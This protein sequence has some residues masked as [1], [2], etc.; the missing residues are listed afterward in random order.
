MKNDLRV[1]ACGVAKRLAKE[2]G[3]PGAKP[4]TFM[5]EAW[6]IVKSGGETPKFWTV[7]YKMMKGWM[8]AIVQAPSKE[9]ATKKF[10]DPSDQF[11]PRSE[12]RAVRETKKI[13]ANWEV[14]MKD[15]QVFKL[16]FE[17]DLT[18]NAIVEATQKQKRVKLKTWEIMSATVAR[19]ESI[20][21]AG[22]G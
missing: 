14:T 3:V 8:K 20:I 5:K 16:T 21:H 1:I 2:S 18:K 9:E 4:N 17:V 13:P 10:N 11:G 22:R 15:Y 7:E 19:K 6:A 12:I